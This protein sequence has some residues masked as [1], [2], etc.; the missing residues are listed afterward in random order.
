MG[1]FSRL[2]EKRSSSRPGTSDGSYKQSEKMK[3]VKVKED[4]AKDREKRDRSL[5]LSPSKE[6]DPA[7]LRKRTSS[8]THY[9]TQGALGAGMAGAVAAAGVSVGGAPTLKA[10]Q[11]ILEQIGEPDHNGWM[12]KKSERY[13]SW[14]LRYFVLKGPHLYWLRSN[15]ITVRAISP[16]PSWLLRF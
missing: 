15:N 12:R 5:S 8:S 2:R 13:N 4:L 14:K 11:S 10:G 9:P 7:L 6:R 1:T 16:W 3:P